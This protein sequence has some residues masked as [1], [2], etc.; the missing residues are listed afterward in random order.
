LVILTRRTPAR[1]KRFLV[2]EE[3][4]ARVIRFATIAA[5]RQSRFD[6]VKAMTPNGFSRYGQLG[7]RVAVQYLP[8][9]THW[10]KTL[11]K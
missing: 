10:D 11:R 8:H 3:F 7:Y 2:I 6:E 9:V 5:T 4:V 1:R